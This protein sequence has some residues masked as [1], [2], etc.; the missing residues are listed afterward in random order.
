MAN[1]DIPVTGSAPTGSGSQT[2]FRIEVANGKADNDG[3]LN[4]RATPGKTLHIFVDTG[5]GQEFEHDLNNARWT[6]RITE[7]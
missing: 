5:L 1:G 7:R 6:L 4:V 2:T 3:H